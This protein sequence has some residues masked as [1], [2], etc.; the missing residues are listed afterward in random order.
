MPILATN[1]SAATLSHLCTSTTSPLPPNTCIGSRR[2]CQ[3][4]CCQPVAQITHTDSKA[5]QLHLL[6]HACIA[7][8][9][10]MCLQS[11]IQ[12][13]VERKGV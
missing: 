12:I 6:V 5:Q 11:G 10:L 4:H 9:G 2:M 13:G 1:A 3:E 8:D 7:G